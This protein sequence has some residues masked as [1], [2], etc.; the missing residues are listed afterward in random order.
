MFRCAQPLRA[1]RR[2][3]S[4]SPDQIASI[5]QTLTS[6]SPSGSAI[7]RTVSSVTSVAS[8]ADFFGHEAQMTPAAGIRFASAAISCSSVFA[9]VAKTWAMS[10][11][12]RAGASVRSVARRPTI[13]A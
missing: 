2:R 8:P 10:N 6:T 1:E 12:P 3:T 13:F 11:A 4:L 9:D 5:A 7:V